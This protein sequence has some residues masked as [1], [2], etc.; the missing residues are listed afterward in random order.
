MKIVL[1][2]GVLVGL[3]G[4]EAKPKPPKIFVDKDACPFE[5]CRYGTWS[6][7]KDTALYDKVGGTRTIGKATRG[8]QVTA[9]TGEVHTV[10]F[11]TKSKDG[12]VFYLL[13]Y[14][15]EGT[16]KVWRDGVVE[17]GVEADVQGKKRPQST[18]WVK[19]QLRGGKVGWSREPNHFG[20]KDGCG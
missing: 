1:L 5:C 19:I 14:Q 17:D 12:K 7:E 13:T 9:V 2:L 6:V 11:E 15:G 16:W 20:N 4:A 18:W 8:T 3:N 10:P